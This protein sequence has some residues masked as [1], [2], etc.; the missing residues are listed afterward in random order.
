MFYFLLYLRFLQFDLSCYCL[1]LTFHFP[2]STF[3]N[4]LST[5]HFRLSISPFT[6]N[7]ILTLS[8]FQLSTFHFTLTFHF[9]LFT[10]YLSLPTLYIC[11]LP[12]Y[13][14]L[15][16]VYFSQSTFTVYCLLFISTSHLLHFHFLLATFH[17]LPLLLLSELTASIT[18]NF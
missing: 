9:P 6:C 18:A 16:V 8:T 11:H 2:H 15:S 7:V 10:L 4:S 13:F 3:Y 5:F 14:P 17:F 1:L 12:L